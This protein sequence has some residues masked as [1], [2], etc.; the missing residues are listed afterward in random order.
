MFADFEI[1]LQ[2]GN[3]STAHEPNALVSVRDASI[4]R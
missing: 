3:F 1:Q 2:E 4:L